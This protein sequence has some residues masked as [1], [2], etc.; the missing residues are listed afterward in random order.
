MSTSK[1]RKSAGA[2]LIIFLTFQVNA[3]QESPYQINWKKDLLILGG[4][5]GLFSVGFVLAN[6]VDPL[7]VEEILLLDRRDVV[8]FD[9]SATNRYS[10]TAADISDGL[11]LTS[12]VLPFSLIAGKRV[13]GN[14]GTTALLL[15]ESFFISAGITNIA[16]GLTKRT[17]PFAYNADVPLE[18]KTG[19]DTRLSFFSGHVSTSAVLSFFTA[20][21][22]SDYYPDS[23]F[24]PLV[25]AA[26][27]TL[28]AVTGLNRYL[29][30][31]HYPSDVIVGYVVGA[32]TGYLVPHFHKKK[33]R[34]RN[35]QIIPTTNLGSGQ[36][37]TF[38][39]T[40]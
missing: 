32:L 19:R 30:G 8:G 40:F 22:Y 34:K 1:F 27:A 28:P 25:W 35:L 9:R 16:K 3:Q 18:K 39:L 4:S 2:L 6:G 21:V 33:S 23:K 13:R 17:R 29:A 26:A 10:T 12:L 24:K 36:R 31:K 14:L 15:G 37:M 11:L 38:L 7:S 20:K 5:A